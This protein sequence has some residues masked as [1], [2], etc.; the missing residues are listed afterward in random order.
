LSLVINSIMLPKSWNLNSSL[1]GSFLKYMKYYQLRTMTILN[2][3]L[4]RLRWCT[5]AVLI[6]PLMHSC[7]WSSWIVHFINVTAS[8]SSTRD[9][10]PGP[11]VSQYSLSMKAHKLLLSIP[12]DHLNSLDCCN[13]SWKSSRIYS[14]PYLKIRE[15]S[16]QCEYND[17]KYDDIYF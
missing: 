8:C 13:R 7:S 17:I 3:P 14:H 16:V 11:I 10:D 4:I 6:F 5:H 15:C 9:P 1:V 2:F 12:F